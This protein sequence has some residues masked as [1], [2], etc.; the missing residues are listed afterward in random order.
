MSAT[1]FSHDT[2]CE[3]AGAFHGRALLD[4]PTPR[5]VVCRSD[6]PALV[7]G[8]V[9]RDSVVDDGALARHGVD[10]TRRHS[11]GGAVLVE[12]NAMVW[13]DVVVAADD[14]RFAN[15]AGDV[16]GSMQWMGTQIRAAL[17]SLGVEEVAVHDGPMVCTDWCR[18][19]CFAGIGPGEVVQGDRKL[20]GISQR[21]TRAG[22]R[23]QCAVHTRW[24]PELL[25]SLL[26]PPRPRLDELPDVATVDERVAREL[27]GAL[28]TVLN[29]L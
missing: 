16:R 4:D 26:A 12:P 29:A 19:V 15:V 2:F 11:G 24:N 10:V 7:L 21:R 22:S 20:A 28:V 25:L 17:E 6:A 9:Q 13:F 23:F 14:P 27:P 1:A 5:V 3:S 18:L 8:S